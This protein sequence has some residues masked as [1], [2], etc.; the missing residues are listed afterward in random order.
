MDL[1]GKTALVTGGSRGIGRAIALRLAQA[2]A[3]VAVNYLRQGGRAKETSEE[4]R[5]HGVRS[6][7]IKANVA[8]AG[9]I[10]SMFDTFEAEIGRLDI[11]ISNAASGVLRPAMELTMRHWHWTM[12]INAGTLLPLV[13]RAVPL[14][15][16]EGGKIV[17]VSSLGATRAIPNYTAVGASKAALESLV[18]HLS[19]ELAPQGINVNA[20]SAGIVDTEALRH[21]PNRSELIETTSSRT[22]AGRLTEPEDVADTVLFL[23]SPLAKMIHG[24]TVVVDGGYSILA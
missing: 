20:I 1:K 19:L 3:D 16:R 23:V 6:L 22:P 11:L 12:D 7:S 17:A 13:Q 8:D 15:S 10:A 5:R 18:R 14:M 2:G 21:F 9:D 24:Q 4:I